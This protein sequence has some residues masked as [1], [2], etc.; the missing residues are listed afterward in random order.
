MVTGQFDTRVL[1]PSSEY[2]QVRLGYCTVSS[3]PW[4]REQARGCTR[5]GM[6]AHNGGGTAPMLHGTRQLAPARTYLQLSFRHPCC[7]P[8]S[9]PS[10]SLV[11]LVQGKVL[12]G[13]LS[14]HSR[15]CCLRPCV[16]FAACRATLN[17]LLLHSRVPEGITPYGLPNVFWV[18]MPANQLPFVMHHLPC[19]ITAH[20][21]LPRLPRPLLAA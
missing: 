11:S 9:R 2:Y 1:N 20:P 5:G 6:H 16:L 21:R 13:Q 4:Q 14:F 18:S 19:W 12:G 7:S 10:P 8:A 3:M 17:C 15:R